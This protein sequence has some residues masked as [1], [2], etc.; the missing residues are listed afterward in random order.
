MYTTLQKYVISAMWDT[1][2]YS[3]VSPHG[4]GWK[5]MPQITYVHIPEQ[6]TMHS[7]GKLLTCAACCKQDDFDWHSDIQNGLENFLSN[8]L[9]M[10]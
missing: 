5:A 10:W 7:T 2:L 4:Q 3:S 6:M 9:L 1:E 8:N